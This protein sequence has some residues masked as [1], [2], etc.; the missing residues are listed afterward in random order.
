LGQDGLIIAGT[1]WL[2]ALGLRATA[3]G[4]WSRANAAVV[5]A[6]ATTL[7]LA[8]MVYLPLV[9]LPV[10]AR[11]TR[12]DRLRWVQPPVLAVILAAALLAVWLRMNAAISV[13]M[14][15]GMPEPRAQVNFLV[16]HPGNFVGILG[17]TY[18]NW[19]FLIG[20]IFTFG[21][22]NIG[23]VMA[24]LWLTLAALALAVSSGDP[25]AKLLRPIDR[26]WTMLL[27]AAIVILLSLALYIAGTPLGADVIWGLQGRYFVPLV[28]PLFLVCLPTRP[29]TG[30]LAPL[31]IAS[32]MV[33]ANL[34]VLQAIALEY[35]R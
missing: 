25:C 23:P 4:E 13:P 2:V 8:K 29:D 32:L 34:A 6:L 28:L 27:L 33:L 19:G 17:Q 16:H 18:T 7:T 15:A 12:V 21:W 20:Q 31:A 5:I 9:L 10:L 14:H 11:Q 35:Y 26:A 24:A 22:L 3:E 1:A 30:P